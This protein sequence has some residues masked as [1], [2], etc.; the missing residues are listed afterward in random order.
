MPD[1]TVYIYDKS[2]KE[3]ADE[4]GVSESAISQ[5]HDRM[6]THLAYFFYT[7]KEFIQMDLYKRN[8]REFQYSFMNIVKE[9]DKKKVLKLI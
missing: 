2:Q 6:L 1:R 5:A 3:I 8:K 4:L 7:D 9:M